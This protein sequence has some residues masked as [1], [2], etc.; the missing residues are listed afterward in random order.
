MSVPTSDF[1]I[2]ADLVEIAGDSL[3]IVWINQAGGVTGRF[4]DGNETNP[5]FIKRNPLGGSEDLALEAQKL[6]W[7]HLRHPSPRV[8]DYFRRG[9]VEFLI[10]EAIPGTS[11]IDPTNVAQPNETIATI[12][13]RL[14]F[15]HELPV[16]DCPWTWSLADRAAQA[17]RPLNPELT[18]PADD[19][20]VV[21]HGDPC[22]PN[23]LLDAHG[24]FVAH[25]DMQRLG[26][27]DRWADLAVVT[28]SFGWNYADYDEFAFWNAYG[29][30]PDPERIEFY[31]EV[32][33]TE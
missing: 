17:I 4:V 22:A 3:D 2:P 7:L 6:E 10:T 13:H 27:A 24:E 11:A 5:K 21:C 8:V 18:V 19:K 29:I 26:V 28:L 12:G 20:L 14:R 16:A 30:E 15:L 32:W 23:T 31:R 25:V 9:D 1:I 33:D